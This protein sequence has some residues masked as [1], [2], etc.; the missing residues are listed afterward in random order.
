M[1]KTDNLQ[2]YLTA[3]ANSCRQAT[4]TNAKF[5]AQDMLVVPLNLS[6]S[7]EDLRVVVTG[8]LNGVKE[9][10]VPYGADYIKSYAYRSSVSGTPRV[11]KIVI[12][13]GVKTIKQY[14]FEN[15][16]RKELHLPST[17]EVMEK[18]IFVKF[19]TYVKFDKTYPGIVYYNGDLKSFL[20]KGE[21]YLTDTT[22]SHADF[23]S[24][25]IDSNVYFN[26]EQ[27][28]N[29]VVPKEITEL[30]G[31]YGWGISGD[32][33]FEDGSQISVINHIPYCNRLY[34]PFG[35][36]AIG[37]VNGCNELHFDGTLVDYLNLTIYQTGAFFNTQSP[38]KVYLKGEL[39][40]STINIPHGVTNI[41]NFA[42][43]NFSY[44][45]KEV[46]V[47][48]T[49]TNI[50][51]QGLYCTSST[52]KGIIRMLAPTPPTLDSTAI[53]TS[54]TSKIIVP[55]ISLNIYKSATNWSKHA[56]I[57]FP[58]TDIEVSIDSTL[59]N[60]SNI[61]YSVDGGAKQQFTNSTL[62]LKGVGTLTIYNTSTDTIKLGSTSGGSEIGTSGPS[63]TITYTF[64]DV[65]TLYIT[66]A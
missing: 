37:G 65:S 33:S 38:R 42:F 45:W 9:I 34:L 2:D 6:N 36:Y 5:N 56:S 35:T 63:T 53:N 14:A 29:V 57:I 46:V 11:D 58:D 28:K 15:I 17:I 41:P 44:N 20:S 4:N 51:W 31:K 25:N 21:L 52:S 59:M 50:G 64:T 18:E 39:V 26:G 62:S 16:Y 10:N 60:N 30:T 40:E 43:M 13:E 27:L 24:L 22:V 3:L 54:G 48:E 8:N 47:P 61:L 32:F 55:A 23:L 12:P 49:V 66:K 1:A 19:G 7:M